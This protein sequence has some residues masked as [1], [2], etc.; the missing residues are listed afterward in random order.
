M[1]MHMDGGTKEHF[2]G[3]LQ[4][5]YPDLVPMYEELYASR[6]VK[7]DYEKR[8]QETVSLMRE[9]FDVKRRR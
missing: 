5:E 4:R 6:Y 9:R 1:V 3:L 8:V 2:M 7:K